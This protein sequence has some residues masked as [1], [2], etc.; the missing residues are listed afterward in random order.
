M[1]GCSRPC[2]LVILQNLPFHLKNAQLLPTACVAQPGPTPTLLCALGL[3]AH[4]GPPGQ[5][6]PLC[7]FSSFPCDP[8]PGSRQTATLG[9]AGHREGRLSR[10]P[11]GQPPL[12][13]GWVEPSVPAP[14]GPGCWC[15]RGIS[16]GLSLGGMGCALRGGCHWARVQAPGRQHPALE[17]KL[18]SLRSVLSVSM[19]T[20][21]PARSGH[22][23]HAE[24]EPGTP[25]TLAAA[26]TPLC[27]PCP[28][29][30]H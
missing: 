29:L 20:A 24:C 16:M 2:E 5:S 7:V 26:D 14:R 13:G 21:L 12:P 1:G 4:S 22:V 27:C 9:D 15:H 11:P 17:Q 30:G 18:S 19:A 23:A 8:V 10:G 6:W 25:A 28:H 3:P